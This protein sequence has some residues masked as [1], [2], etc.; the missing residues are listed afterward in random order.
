MENNLINVQI[1]ERDGLGLVVS[2][3]VI[4]QGLGK[5]HKHVLE[6]LDKIVLEQESSRAEISTLFITSGYQAVNG[7][8][9][10][11]YLLTKD[12]F[13]LYMFNIQGYNDFKLAYINKFNEMDAQLKANT[14]QLSLKN[15]IYIDIIGAES[16][17]E[18]ALAIRRLEHEV[19]RPLEDKAEYFD[20]LVDK[21]LHTNFRDTAKEFGM[22]QTD[23]IDWLLEK[24]Y[25]YRDQKGN[26]KPTAK[27][28]N[29]EYMVLKESINRHNGLAIVQTLITAKGRAAFRRFLKLK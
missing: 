11:E 29:E 25:V 12:G 15:Q 9:N 26:L 13:T 19:I 7:K 8:K 10:R 18:T 20:E 1:E 3:R 23:F 28:M 6:S 16:E 2:S 21:D 22:R 5:Q 24:S 17:V 27:S 14:P 4:A